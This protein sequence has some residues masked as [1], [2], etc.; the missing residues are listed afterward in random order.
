MAAE[1]LD[2]AYQ[3]QTSVI[4]SMLIDE[5][6]IPLVLSK[7]APEDFIDGTCKATFRAVRKL[8]LAGRPADPVTVVDAMRGGDRYISWVREVM[9]ATPTAANVEE[10]IPMVRRAA[11]RRRVLELAE[12]LA[13]ADDDRLDGL[14][15]EMASALSSTE[16]MRRMTAAERVAD[17]YERMKRPEKPRYLPW[18]LPVADRNV[19][20]ELGDMILLGGYPLARLPAGRLH[21]VGQR[22][23]CERL[24]CRRSRRAAGRGLREEDVNMA[25][26]RR[27]GK[28]AESAQEAQDK[29]GMDQDARETEHAPGGVQE[30]A[31]AVQDPY[32]E[33]MEPD[34]APEPAGQAREAPGG[35]EDGEPAGFIEYAVAGCRWLRLRQK[36]SLAAEVVATLPCGMGVMACTRPVVPGWRQVF[37][38]RLCGWVMDEF[39]EPLEAAEADDG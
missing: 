19:Y 29:L 3:A 18:G 33:L 32:E 17:F 25:K 15:R 22:G 9:E 23:V 34:P 26:A 16:R 31:E 27:A 13:E 20:A 28:A 12:G 38:G 4:G 14:V 8:T 5:R 24:Y 2:R 6:C 36:P 39:L 37:S 10:Y 1:I 7:L 21:G 11:V 30:G 35:V